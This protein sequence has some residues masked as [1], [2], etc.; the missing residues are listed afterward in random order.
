MSAATS[1]S[2]ILQ[3]SGP[4]LAAFVGC[5]PLILQHAANRVHWK[6]TRCSKSNS[7]IFLKRGG[8]LHQL[9]VSAPEYFST[10]V[11]K[12]KEKSPSTMLRIDLGHGNQTDNGWFPQLNQSRPCGEEL[13]PNSFAS[14]WCL[15]RV[16]LKS[17]I[18]RDSEAR[19]RRSPTAKRTLFST[20]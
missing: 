11:T 5:K 4:S 19:R 20:A 3:H 2:R 13:V 12:R 9:W 14:F 18:G 6:N 7:C 17:S 8:C 10:I 1:L 15:A 16:V